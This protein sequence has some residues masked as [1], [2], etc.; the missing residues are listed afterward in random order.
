M[1]RG[2]PHSGEFRQSAEA[3]AVVALGGSRCLCAPADVRSAPGAHE[4]HINPTLGSAFEVRHFDAFPTVSRAWPA[5]H[6][7]LDAVEGGELHMS[8]T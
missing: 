8:G 6:P 5:L 3:A 4:P 7:A 2:R 1:F